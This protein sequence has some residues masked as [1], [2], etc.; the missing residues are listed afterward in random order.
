MTNSDNE[1]GPDLLSALNALHEAIG[2]PTPGMMQVQLDQ[3]AVAR[4]TFYDL[5]KG[6]AVLPEW[7]TVESFVAACLAYAARKKITLA[8]DLGSIGWWERLHEAKRATVRVQLRTPGMDL[9]GTWHPNETE[10]AAAWELYVELVTRVALVPLAEDGGVDRETLTS[11][12]LLFGIHRDVLRRYG[13]TI[14][15]PKPNGEYNLAYLAV[16]TLN[17]VLR[18]FLTTWHP[19]LSEVEARRPSDVSAV[20][21]ERQWPRH[22]E[23]RQALARLRED[24]RTYANW[25]ATACGAPDLIDAMPPTESAE[26]RSMPVAAK[27]SAHVE[28]PG[29]E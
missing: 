6:K 13:P 9:H 4:A 18:P 15:E 29:T 28:D 22:A 23:F 7:R 3:N 26:S 17:Y 12:H 11:I 27:D 5:L 25:L 2:K 24:L 10:R 19:L 8:P 1:S 21:N 16:S 20:T 14:A